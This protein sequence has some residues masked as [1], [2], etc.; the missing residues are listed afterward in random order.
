[1]KLL[2]H[3]QQRD[4]ICAENQELK[5][6]VAELTDRLSVVERIATDPAKR[7]SREIE[8]LR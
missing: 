6:R 4:A 8:R 2:G 3:K 5:R 7:V 1:V